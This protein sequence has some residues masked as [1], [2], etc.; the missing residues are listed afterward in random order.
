M[1]LLKAWAERWYVGIAVLGEPV[2]PDNGEVGEV[3]D[4]PNVPKQALK[5]P[6]HGVLGTI[7]RV[8]HS[9]TWVR[10]FEMLLFVKFP[11]VSLV[12]ALNYEVEGYWARAENH[13]SL[14]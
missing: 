9:Q 11:V 7:L 12:L 10:Q 3:V 6:R 2:M 8:H 4:T 13:D 14:R 1:M 5:I